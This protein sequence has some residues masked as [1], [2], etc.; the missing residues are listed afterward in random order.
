ME[1]PPVDAAPTVGTTAH[2]A[3]TAR[4]LVGYSVEGAATAL[5]VT[6]G[7]VRDIESGAVEL[8]P[9]LRALMEDAYGISLA[10]LI[11]EAPARL[12]RTPISYDA[13][14]G[15]LRVG[16][17]GVRFRLGL[18]DNDVLLRGFTSAVRRQRQLPPSIPLQL[19]KAD[20]PVLATLLDLTDE[21]LDRRAQFWFGQ[22]PQTAQ[23]FRRMLKLAKG[24]TPSQ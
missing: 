13:T 2:A 9:D 4:T 15:V 24:A 6:A 21:D 16:T 19:R 17:L 1:A 7:L 5:G 22:T 20:L 23:G 8:T 18:D 11:Q 14:N 10:S 3:A 12:P